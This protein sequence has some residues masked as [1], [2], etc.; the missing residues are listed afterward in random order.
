MN[1]KMHKIKSLLLGILVFPM[2]CQNDGNQDEKT[3]ETVPVSV[4]KNADSSELVS[5]ILTDSSA[6]EQ[7]TEEL[8]SV[9]NWKIDDFIVKK[10][11]RSSAGVRAQIEYTKEQ[12]ENVKNPFVATYQGCDFGDYFHLTFQDTE[13]NY[14][15]FG[16]GDNNYE[17]Y[18][19]FD[20]TDY[21]DNP[22]YLNKTFKIYWNWKITT[23]PCCE[24][25]YNSVESYQPSI[26]K[27]ELVS[28]KEN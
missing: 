4:E 9:S 10:K 24:G 13:G 25:E 6:L 8:I 20:D 28:T 12:W 23:F 7:K 16:F 21:A 2:G 17:P 26:T 1:Q 27:L 19:L 3:Q 11:D 18:Q 22:N 5:E 15:D 14:Y